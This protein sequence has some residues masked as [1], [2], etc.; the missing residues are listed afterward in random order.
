MEFTHDARRGLG[1]GPG[2]RRRPAEGEERPGLVHRGRVIGRVAWV[3]SKR[4]IRVEARASPRRVRRRRRRIRRPHRPTAIHGSRRCEHD[5]D[6]ARVPGLGTQVPAVRR[7][8]RSA[9]ALHA[10]AVPHPT[11]HLLRVRAVQHG[12]GEHIRRDHPDG[13]GHGLVRGH[14][15]SPAERVLLRVR[16]VA[17]ARGLPRHQVRRG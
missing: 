17:A 15:R 12:Q 7:R 10:F 2:R 3:D 9:V 8:P 1:R 16:A 14:R 13:Q 4:I 5:E 6:G 11:R